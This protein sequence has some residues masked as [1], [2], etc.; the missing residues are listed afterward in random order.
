VIGADGKVFAPEPAAD[1][2]SKP[3][4]ARH[5]LMVLMSMGTNAVRQLRQIIRG[6]YPGAVNELTQL[7][8]YEDQISLIRARGDARLFT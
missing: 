2:G 1:G 6:L 4:G 5:P 3:R 8:K 7:E